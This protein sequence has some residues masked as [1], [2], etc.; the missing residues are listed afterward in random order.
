[1]KARWTTTET[2]GSLNCR[3]V[4]SRR[5]RASST[6]ACNA[7]RS[8]SRITN[9]LRRN[10]KDRQRL[11]LQLLRLRRNQHRSQAVPPRR[12]SN[13]RLPRAL[14]RQRRTRRRR[15]YQLAQLLQRRPSRVVILRNRHQ[16]QR[17]LNLR[18][19]S[20]RPASRPFTILKKSCPAQQHSPKQ[21]N[22]R[23]SRVSKMKLRK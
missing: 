12:S 13:R 14:A 9:Q 15:S 21:R 6:F 5:L 22:L 18:R 19:N 4:R 2:L 16:S 8:A 3:T 17:R 1:M 10:P 7:E 11:P 20:H 23:R